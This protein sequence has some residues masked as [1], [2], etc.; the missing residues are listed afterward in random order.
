MIARVCVYCS[1][2]QSIHEDYHRAARELG[3]HLAEASVRIVYGGGAVGSMGHL[4]DGALAAGGE[5]TGV[6]PKF[7]DELEWGHGRVTELQIV[8]NM[9]QRKSEMMA[10]S[11]AVVALPGGC[12]TFEELFEAITWKRLGIY[13]RPIVLVNTRGFFDPCLQLLE[14]CV[15]EHFMGARH[16]DMWQVVDA[17]AEVIAAI[18]EAP[19]WDEAARGFAVQ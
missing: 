11:D 1:S 6:L 14:R 12:G 13:C 2:S 5:V 10:G 3:A 16:R 8:D 15:E 19:P 4:A 17:P 9:H 18:E 7:M